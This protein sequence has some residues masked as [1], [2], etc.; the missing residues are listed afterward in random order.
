[1]NICTYN[2]R[3]LS[4]DDSMIE[5][6]EEILRIKWNIIGLSE[7]RRKGKRSIILNNTG[8]TVYYSGSH[9]QTHGV[10]FVVN[11]N[12]SYKVISFR[13]LSDRVAEL[14]VHINKRYHLK[15]VQVYLPT[16]SDPDEEIEKVYEDIHIIVKQ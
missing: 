15:C 2:A 6:D 14:P 11:K 10:G 4:S 13:G 12:I 8:H 16:I 5:L 3:S 1:M 7:V 9:E